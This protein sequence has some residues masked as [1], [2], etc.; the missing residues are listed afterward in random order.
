MNVEDILEMLEVFVEIFFEFFFLN[1]NWFFDIIFS[2]NG[3]ELGIWMSFG[4]FV[5]ICGK[6]MFDW[7]LDNFN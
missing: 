1:D 7:Y 6:Y 4:D 3:V 2:L 5:D